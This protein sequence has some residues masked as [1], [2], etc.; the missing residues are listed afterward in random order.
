MD[1]RSSLV[2]VTEHPCRAILSEAKDLEPGGS[3]ASPGM[4]DPK[5]MSRNGNT[6]SIPRGA[7]VRSRRR[8]G[9]V[10][11]LV[12]IVVTMI[13]LAG[14]SFACL[15][16]TESKAVRL[17][18]DE[19]QLLSVA[20]S[21]EE[22][23]KVLLEQPLATRSDIGG[24]YDNPNLFRG[25]LVF[26]E[27]N[28]RARF[29]VVSPRIEQGEV[30]GL[31]FGLEN[32]S[33]KLHLGSVLAW[34]K[35][36]AGA[37][38][39]ALL[40]LPGMTETI[41]DSILD[42]MDPDTR[43]RQFGAEEDYYASRAMPYGPRNA[44]PVS[45]EELLLVRGMSRALLFG[46]DANFNHMLDADESESFADRME[47]LRA[48][49]DSKW[50]TLLTV[51]SAERN[52]TPDG[53]P[54]IWLNDPDLAKLYKQLTAAFGRTAAEFVVAYRQFGPY[55]GSSSSASLGLVFR[56]DLAAPPRYNLNSVLDLVGARVRATVRLANSYAFLTS[57]F[58]LTGQDAREQ[59]LHLMDMTSTVPTPWISGR[60]NI[61]LAPQIVLQCIPG[62]YD[63]LIG[64]IMAGRD[65]SGRE[66]DPE[67]RHPLWLLTE[68]LVDLP[69]MKTLL[70]FITGGGDVYRG[71]I[72]AYF[73][74]GGATARVEVV[75]DATGPTP[76]QVYWK[77]LRGFGRG[78]PRNMI[79]DAPTQGNAPS[80]VPT[81]DATDG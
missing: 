21:G 51:Y 40:K 39:Q 69:R 71:Q 30:R 81:R 1:A 20:A 29:S 6:S 63:S 11:F 78:Y 3:S 28:R 66:D 22:L 74:D 67:R 43:P 79:G 56:P 23:I 61:N 53:Q 45:L 77:D 2:S 26:D 80:N 46:T 12:F 14:F 17:H 68:G 62:M 60:V 36:Q 73:D 10:L 7:P 58:S 4:T 38:R 57:P 31:R 19:L 8:S 75:V 9:F 50:S 35:L 32:E 72:V 5:V 54:R 27:P 24:Y 47:S 15:M 37:G 33:A 49:A 55:T 76:R 44:V 52:L 41:A 25:I 48:G 16:G 13:S 64:R 59:L 34:E 18:G 65:N 70:P 42:W